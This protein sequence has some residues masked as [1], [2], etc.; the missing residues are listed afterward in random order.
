MSYFFAFCSFGLHSVQSWEQ[1]KYFFGALYKNSDVYLTLKRCF[2]EQG[3]T[4]ALA[5]H[6]RS[7]RGLTLFVLENTIF[8]QGIFWKI[9]FGKF[10]G[11]VDNLSKHVATLALPLQL[12]KL[13]TS[14]Y[15]VWT[16]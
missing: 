4:H 3:S 5:S 9:M 6:A 11:D 10:V 13:R 16:R 8:Q 7:Y 12:T 14:S 1:K 15:V 2:R